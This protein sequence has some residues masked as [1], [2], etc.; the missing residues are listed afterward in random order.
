[1]SFDMDYSVLENGMISIPFTRTDGQYTLQDALVMV[2]TEFESLSEPDIIAMQDD[3][4]AKWVSY[5]I[6]ASNA[7]PQE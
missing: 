2:A 3:R 4:F 5:V 6:T 1:M 7:P